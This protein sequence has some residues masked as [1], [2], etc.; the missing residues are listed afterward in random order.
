MPLQMNPM[1]DLWTLRGWQQHAA[2]QTQGSSWVAC[3]SWNHKWCQTP[4]HPKMLY[5]QDSQLLFG[6]ISFRHISNK[7]DPSV[8]ANSENSEILGASAFSRGSSRRR[9]SVQG[10]HECTSW[11]SLRPTLGDVMESRVRGSGHQ[12]ISLQAEIHN[13]DNMYIY[14]YYIYSSIIN[15]IYYIYVYIVYHE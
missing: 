9:R 12:I 4:F 5:P 7:L 11:R 3:S 14:I 10:Y 6:Q 13:I 8:P 1:A 2:L 15:S